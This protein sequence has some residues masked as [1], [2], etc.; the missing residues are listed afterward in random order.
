MPEAH[1]PPYAQFLMDAFTRGDSELTSAFGSHIHWGWWAHADDGDG[2]ASDFAVAADRMCLRMFDTAG[3]RDGMSILDAGCGFGGTVANL[4]ARFSQVCLTGLNIDSRQLERAR[5]RVKPRPGNQIEFVQ[6]D[7]CA[8]P[9]PDASFD[10]VFAVE[11]IFHFLDRRKFFDEVYR[12]LRPE[13]RLVISDFVPTESFLPA[14][15]AQDL[16]F[17]AYQ[18]R[19]SGAVNVRYSLSRYRA[20]ARERGFES[21]HEQDITTHTLPTYKAVRRLLPRFRAGTALATTGLVMLELV[22]RM[23][24]LQYMILSFGRR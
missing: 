23:R 24:M 7:A 22:T 6:G 19:F 14:L 1:A 11:C 21:L 3:I 5:E 8:M 4:D 15:A 13:G 9:L 18:R 20:L 16:L 17:G 2:T 10:V 12:V